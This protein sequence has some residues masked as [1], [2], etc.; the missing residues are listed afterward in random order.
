MRPRGWQTMPDRCPT[1]RIV[2]LA[3][4]L[5]CSLAAVEAV[6]QPEPDGSETPPERSPSRPA[7]VAPPGPDEDDWPVFAQPGFYVAAGWM[8]APEDF[9]EGRDFVVQNSTG[10]FARAGYRIHPLVA[11]E[12]R[13]QWLEGFEIKSDRRTFEGQVKGW[14]ATANHIKLV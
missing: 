1:A 2:A 9:G 8:Y 13:A 12:A 7:P 5:A 10:I 14:V 4:A 11:F 6:A 3:A